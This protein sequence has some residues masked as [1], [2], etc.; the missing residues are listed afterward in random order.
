MHHHRLELEWCHMYEVAANVLNGVEFFQLLVE[1]DAKLS[2][3]E[4]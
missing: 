2:S 1:S 3:I 4:F